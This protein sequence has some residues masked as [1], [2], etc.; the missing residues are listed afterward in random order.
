[1]NT[2]IIFVLLHQPIILGQPVPCMQDNT[3]P[4]EIDSISLHVFIPASSLK[5]VEFQFDLARVHSN[6]T[7]ID[8]L[9]LY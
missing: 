3:L 4:I 1:M 5:N 8:N 6:N 7:F 9:E 2:Q